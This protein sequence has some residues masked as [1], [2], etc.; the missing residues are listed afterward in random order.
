MY[1][2]LILDGRRQRLTKEDDVGL[3]LSTCQ[4]AV[5][6]NTVSAGGRGRHEPASASATAT[7]NRLLPLGDTSLAIRDVERHVIRARELDVSVG[8]GPGES[9]LS[10]Y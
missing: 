6:Y 10:Q 2:R 8:V 9:G 1:S 7:H 4:K 3:D 5:P